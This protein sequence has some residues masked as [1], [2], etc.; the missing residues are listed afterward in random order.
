MA[1]SEIT[2]LGAGLR[3]ITTPIPNAQA[4]SIAY[5]VGIGSRVRLRRVADDR[6]VTVTFLGPWDTDLANR[7]YS[8]QTQLA[9]EFLGKGVGDTGSLK[10]EGLEGEYRIEGL[11]CGVE[12]EE[13]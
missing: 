11:A 5:F 1:N 4:A 2:T 8:Y 12:E 3:V 9:K 7:T 6:E 10:I 13:A